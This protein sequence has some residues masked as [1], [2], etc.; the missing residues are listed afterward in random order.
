MTASRSSLASLALASLVWAAGAGRVAAHG[1]E[2]SILDVRIG[3]SGR[4]DL[5]WTEPT[6]LL[7]GPGLQ[8]SPGALRV[9]PPAGCR[10]ASARASEAVARGTVTRWSVEC[11]AAARRAG[12]V[13]RVP[14]LAGTAKLVIVRVREPGWREARIELVTGRRDAVPLAGGPSTLEARGARSGG[15]GG[16]PGP[17]RGS[18]GWIVAGAAGMVFAA[19]SARAGR[20]AGFVYRTA[21]AYAI[22]VV[23]AAA[24]GLA[25]AGG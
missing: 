6:G 20:R 13:L 16:A 11:G 2:P 9:E 5:A 15:G 17:A 10:V 3:E 1:V 7:D 8:L 23:A 21:L 4:L 12:A 25:I 18:S 22:G 19:R 24:A 14:G